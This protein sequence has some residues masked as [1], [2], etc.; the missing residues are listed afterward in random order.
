MHVIDGGHHKDVHDVVGVA[1]SVALAWEP[2]LRDVDCPDVSPGDGQ[3]VLQDDVAG[4]EGGAASPG[5]Q[6]HTQTQHPDEERGG[7][8]EPGAWSVST[9]CTC[10]Q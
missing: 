1:E 7:E 2:L 4:G 3:H 6:T 5:G 9:E 10:V 8:R